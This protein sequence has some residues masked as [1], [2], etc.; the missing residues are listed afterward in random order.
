MH[1]THTSYTVQHPALDD[2][3]KDLIHLCAFPPVRKRGANVLSILPVCVSIRKR[4]PCICEESNHA[5]TPMTAVADKLE[6]NDMTTLEIC[7][8]L[9]PLFKTLLG[10]KSSMGDSTNAT[11][12]NT[13][14]AATEA[15]II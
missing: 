9:I 11:I 4:Q 12:L 3:A 6:N 10:A 7:R 5:V 8:M 13:M 15:G 1:L 2:Q 14:V